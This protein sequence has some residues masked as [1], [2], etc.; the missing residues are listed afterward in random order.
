MK[1]KKCRVLDGPPTFEG[2]ASGMSAMRNGG[3]SQI[4]GIQDG[5][6]NTEY[7]SNGVEHMFTCRK[8]VGCIKTVVESGPRP[9]R[10][11]PPAVLWHVPMGK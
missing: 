4:S 9:S 5:A 1:T 2:K 10:A 11:D 8:Q 7:S 6:V 3:L